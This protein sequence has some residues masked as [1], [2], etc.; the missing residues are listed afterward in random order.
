MSFAM[1]EMKIVL[2]AVLRAY[3]LAPVGGLH[4]PPRR[5]NITVRPARGARVRLEPR[6]AEIPLAA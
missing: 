5:R 1:L 2:P 6:R 4:E 3:E